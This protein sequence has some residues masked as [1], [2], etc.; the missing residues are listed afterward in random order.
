MAEVRRRG[1][2]TRV[3]VFCSDEDDEDIRRLLDQGVAGYVLKEEPPEK[4]VEA[5]RTV[6]EGGQ[7]FSQKIAARLA[8]GFKQLPPC[9]EDL[10]RREAEVLNLLKESLTN[11]EIAAKLFV[12]T[13][14]V[15]FHLRNIYAKLGVG[16]RGEAMVWAVENGTVTR[17]FGI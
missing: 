9:S 15:R 12:T 2:S 4:L 5:I 8:E 14:T 6:A 10:T 3:L 13:R 17:K 11:Q 1:S 7:W 16:R